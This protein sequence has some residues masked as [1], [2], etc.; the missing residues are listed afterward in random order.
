MNSERLGKLAVVTGASSGIGF[1][2]AKVLTEND[3]EVLMVAENDVD[4]AAATLGV[5]GGKV[6]PLRADLST[7][8]GNERV[9]ATIAAYG[10][11]VD[12]LA[13]NAGVGVAG[14]FLETALD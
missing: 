2:L 4:A 12:V 9:I 6:M 10:Q 5:T 3:F 1:E 14:S 7:Y 8:E 13:L 11:A